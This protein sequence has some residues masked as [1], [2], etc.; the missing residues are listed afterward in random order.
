MKRVIAMLLAVMMLFTSGG[1]ILAA[2][3]P[4]DNSNA[5]RSGDMILPTGVM[6][7]EVTAIPQTEIPE[8]MDMD[9]NSVAINK[10]SKVYNHQW[11][12][13]STN[14]YYNQLSAKQ[15]EVWD[16]L[17]AVCIYYL[18]NKETIPGCMLDTVSLSE[19]M[20]IEDLKVF[21]QLFM[22]SNPQY[23]F[24][25]NGFSYYYGSSYETA[26]GI[27]LKC[28]S[29]FADGNDRAAATKKVKK[30][31]NAWEKIVGKCSSEEEKVKVIHDLICDKVA[32]NHAVFADGYIS[33]EEEQQYLTQTAYSVL[34][35]DSTV[36]AG[37]SDAMAIMCN[38][39]G[40]DA[41]S[42]TSYDHQ[43]NKVRINDIWYNYDA[44]WG[45]SDEDGVYYG[46]F[47]RSDESYEAHGYSHI[48]E[49]FWA[50]YS[51]SANIDVEPS[52]PWS[53]PGTY[54]DISKTTAAPKI[55]I[56]RSGD[57]YVVKISCDTSKATIYYTTDGTDPSV[58]ATKATKYKKAFKVKGTCTIKAIAVRTGY[59]DSSITSKATKVESLEDATVTLSKTKYNYDGKSKKPTATVI[60]DGKTLVE[61]TDYTVKYKNNKKIGKAT[62]TIT[63]IN[64]YKGTIKKTFTISAKKGKTFTSGDNK[65]K[66]TGS[67]T[68]SFIGLKNTKVKKV[69]IPK[70]VEYGGK[71]F[72][73]TAIADK[74]LKGKNKVTEVI[75]GANV[76]TIGKS[77]FESCTKL[78]TI[79]IKSTKLEK[80]GKN[81][82]KKINSKAK[83]KVP[84]NKLKSYKKLLDGKG[85][86]S[87]VKIVKSK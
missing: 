67:S 40:L 25:S 57:S 15:K 83:I 14:Y 73:V 81:A 4:S 1:E 27:I 56:T 66:V 38:G 76:K 85:Q 46:F 6:E 43:W 80:V 12:K 74:A 82:L 79:T 44:T 37:Y 47:A 32:Y 54:P 45:D 34:C 8:A 53:G 36:C 13:Y 16:A 2:E 69:T 31:I 24:L 7:P 65:Y 41:V 5:V 72:K 26:S 60:L 61:D 63:G 21:W 33:P 75:V 23:Y 64:A 30:Q 71:K 77:A 20:S 50:D 51:P 17:D 10:Y 28:Y 42:V 59:L 22:H 78:K 9:S 55:K 58:A 39:A 52:D 62:V 84:K 68:V 18:D 86:G 48:E 3:L 87:K 70:T 19:E 11:D 29:V 49:D 35:G